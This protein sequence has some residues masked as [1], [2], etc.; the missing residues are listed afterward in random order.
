MEAYTRVNAKNT[1]MPRAIREIECLADIVVPMLYRYIEKITFKGK[2]LYIYEMDTK[3]IG[4][5]RKEQILIWQI[6]IWKQFLKM[7]R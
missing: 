5:M 3:Q 2:A 6:L 1:S 7:L 4:D